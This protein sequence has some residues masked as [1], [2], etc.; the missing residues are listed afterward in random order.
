MIAIR[1]N[2]CQGCGLCTEV[3]PKKILTIDKTRVNLRGYTPIHITDFG[4]CIGC[5]LCAIMCPDL[6]FEVGKEVEDGTDLNE[7]E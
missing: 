1:A 2:R 4:S 5:S 3:C 6:V 7:G